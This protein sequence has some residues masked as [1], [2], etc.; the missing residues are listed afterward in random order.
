MRHAVSEVAGEARSVTFSRWGPRVL[1]SLCCIVAGVKDSQLARAG[2]GEEQLESAA[3]TA[4]TAWLAPNRVAYHSGVAGD[5]TGVDRPL[6]APTRRGVER[7]GASL[8]TASGGG[9]DGPIRFGRLVESPTVLGFFGGAVSGAFALVHLL[10]AA[11]GNLSAFIL[12]GAGHGNRSRLPADITVYREGYDGQF[13]YRL[14]LDPLRWSHSAFGITIDSSYRIAR[15]SYPA[16]AWLLAAGHHG[17]VPATLVIANV[18][19][20]G[21]L[22]GFAC[23]LARDMG[24]H[25]AWGL[26]LSAYWGYLWTIARD[27][28][29]LVAAAALVGTL[30]AVRRHRPVLAAVS[31]SIGVL[32]RETLLVFVAAVA[33]TRLVAWVRSRTLAPEG[34]SAGVD[35]PLL[36]GR[37]GIPDV[38]WIVPAL[39]FAAWEV[40]VERTVGTFPVLASASANRGAPFT[41]IV[42]AVGHYAALLPGHAALTWF[43]ELAVLAVVALSAAFAFPSSR[44][45]LHEKLAWIGYVVLSLS[46]S[47]NIW[48]GDVGFR[49]LNEVFLFSVILLLCSPRR[50]RVQSILV[51]LTW[52][53]VF[54]Q[55]ARVV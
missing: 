32:G 7:G 38:V 20:F 45:L 34:T 30:L 51:G 21:L 14:A 9:H 16:L 2:H 48:L 36:L 13:Y 22:T 3:G 29:E 8:R 6:H 40:A 17:A 44:A 10:V 27:L 50:V 37:P 11:K 23:A 39:V 52:A 18:L 26:L 35:R 15:I 19:A 55:L 1:R 54:V 28:T 5:G 25:P 31:L 41:G 33:V 49:S 4:R 42:H 46:L 53:A 43:A 47:D 24:R 12:V